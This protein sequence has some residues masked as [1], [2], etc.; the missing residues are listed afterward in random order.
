MTATSC[1]WI[2]WWAC[3]SHLKM[4]PETSSLNRVLVGPAIHG[5]PTSWYRTL[6]S[7]TVELT[8]VNFDSAYQAITLHILLF[9]GVV[10]MNLSGI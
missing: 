3:G 4:Y 2:E 5:A 6:V 7:I 1:G 9:D 10:T 8:R